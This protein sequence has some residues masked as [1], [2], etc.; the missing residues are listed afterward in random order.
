MDFMACSAQAL[1]FDLDGTL[2]DSA[3]D[4]H[5]ALNRVLAEAGRPAIRLEEVK[6]IV[7]D[8]AARLVERGFERTGA[9]VAAAALPRLVER[10]IA[11]YERALADLTRP[12]EGVPETL[13]MLRARGIRL[14]VC[15]N[16]PE[17]LSL[18]ILE[19][20]GLAPLFDGVAGGDSG[21]VRKP[22]AGHFHATLRRMGA[23]G[24]PAVMVGDSRNDVA[25]ARAASVPV[26]LVDWGY[27]S[28]PPHELGADRIISRF[29]DLPEA[30]RALAGT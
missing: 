27:T 13:A 29:A 25:V 2:I 18:D 23:A 7:G 21:P 15:T 20:L 16:K 12:F 30:L 3:P 4:L 9:P 14:G 5:A 10:F 8:G 22:D 28:I 19:A 24:A 1:V 11:F 26:V 17:R 6:Q